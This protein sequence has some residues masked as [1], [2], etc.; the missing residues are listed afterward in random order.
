MDGDDEKQDI[1]V[2]PELPVQKNTCLDAQLAIR[3]RKLIRDKTQ[4]ELRGLNVS[5]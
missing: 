3:R 5:I 1:S 4:E 2:S